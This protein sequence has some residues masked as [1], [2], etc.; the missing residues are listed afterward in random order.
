MKICFRIG[1]SLLALSLF[2]LFSGCA[3]QPA[4]SRGQPLNDFEVV[5]TSTKRQL[6]SR[7]MAYLRA[8]VADYLAQ[9]GQTASG[10]YYVKIFLG[11]EKGV[12]EGDWVVVRFT[13]YPSAQFALVASYPTYGYP[14]YPRY[15]YD[16]YPFGWWGFSAFSF[17]YYDDPY[18]HGYYPW[19]YPRYSGHWR[20]R[21]HRPGH[22]PDQDDKDR[23][24]PP[25]TDP[26]TPGGHRPSFVPANFV[27]A[28]WNNNGNP[29]VLEG[30][31]REPRIPETFPRQRRPR[32]ERPQ[33]LVTDHDGNRRERPEPLRLEPRARPPERVA[34]P[35]PTAA[36]DL[37]PRVSRSDP[38]PRPERPVYQPP[39]DRG[40]QRYTPP[41]PPPREERSSPP[42]SRSDP[43][44]NDPPPAPAPREFTRDIGRRERD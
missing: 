41:A 35:V 8:K 22:R 39:A 20:D 2:G 11:E 1:V 9:Q 36:P 43:V 10:D 21:D 18:Y 26:R 44:R 32:E 24:R 30:I 16:Y 3:S 27:R 38:P 13:R 12:S 5:E 6:T 17:R 31:D 25:R 19:V 14:A 29:P 42:E 28:R 33:P 37:A 15:T 4:S 7:E 23:P 40:V 34:R